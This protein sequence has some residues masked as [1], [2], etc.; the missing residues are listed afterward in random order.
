[1][2][3]DTF[4]E[5]LQNI[6]EPS[7]TLINANEWYRRF[8]TGKVLEA[9]PLIAETVLNVPQ[10]APDLE[11]EDH[12]VREVITI[13]LCKVLGA[14]ARRDLALV[15]IVDDLYNDELLKETNWEGA[16]TE[17]NQLAFAIVGWLSMSQDKLKE[18]DADSDR[19]AVRARNRC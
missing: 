19:H 9:W 15:E 5:T 2:I 6:A 1:L 7:H 11:V 10:K 12:G 18:Q 17:A 14:M 3:D 16:R 4:F 13:L 8:L